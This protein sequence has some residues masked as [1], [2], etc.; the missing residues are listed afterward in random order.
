LTGKKIHFKLYNRRVVCLLRKILALTA[1]M[2]LLF[3]LT[4]SALE[5]WYLNYDYSYYGA[6]TNDTDS[7]ETAPEN[8]LLPLDNDVTYEGMPS[9]RVNVMDNHSW[10][11]AF[12]TLK[13]P[14][15]LTPY[16]EEGCL[17]FAIKGE[18]GDESLCIGFKSHDGGGGQILG[19]M[20]VQVD[21]TD[22]KVVNIPISD[23]IDHHPFLFIDEIDTFI[24][25][26]AKTT[27]MKFWVADVKVLPY[28]PEPEPTPTPEPTPDPTP[29]PTPKPTP[30]P[31][32]EPTPKPAEEQ[33]D[34]SVTEPDTD[35]GTEASAKESEQD[36]ETSAGAVTAEDTDTILLYVILA[37][38]IVIT[39]LMAVLVI[40]Q[41]RSA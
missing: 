39:A 25:H 11:I 23:I 36:V 20:T 22:W 5:T 32:P 41:K 18:K 8:Q 26:H 21:S 4:A 31:T 1:A 28:T 30:E 19:S 13:A 17:Q 24:M 3:T 29:T 35:K 27:P 10:W 15:D 7:M 37:V 2:M 14:L 12:L 38:L 16:A 40:R 33:P 34:E 6:V 9:M